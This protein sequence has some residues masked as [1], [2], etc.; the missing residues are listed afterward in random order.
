MCIWGKDKLCKWFNRKICECNPIQAF[1]KYGQQINATVHNSALW[2]SKLLLNHFRR[3]QYSF[4]QVWF[5][6]IIILIKV[7]IS[8]S[9]FSPPF[10]I[11]P[12]HIS[13]FTSFLF[14]FALSCSSNLLGLYLFFLLFLLLLLPSLCCSASIAS[15]LTS[16]LYY[17]ATSCPL[18][19]LPSSV[20]SSSSFIHQHHFCYSLSFSLYF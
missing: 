8:T 18:P 13:I 5:C 20:F 6:C 19:I 3:Y 12:H 9:S 4:I 7:L 1:F 15:T 16:H 17:P 11:L 2:K 14:S 10:L